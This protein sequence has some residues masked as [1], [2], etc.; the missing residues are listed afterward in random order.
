MTRPQPA[1]SIVLEPAKHGPTAIEALR[2]ALADP[3]LQLRYRRSTTGTWIDEFGLQIE[4]SEPDSG[5][6]LTPLERDG[7]WVAALI[8]DP[9]LLEEP[10]RVRAACAAIASVIDD[11]RLRAELRAQLRDEQA[12]RARI[13]AASDRQRRRI[14][15][16]L[17]D[18]AQQRLVGL[19]L[20]LQLAGKRADGGRPVTEL[21]V[22][23]VDELEA[24]IADLHELARGLHPAI[25]TDAGLAA[26]VETLAERPG[27]PVELFLDLP[28]R[29]PE[30][31][32]VG[33]YYLVAESLA[34]ANKHSGAQTITVTAG[35]VDDAVDV[36]VR[37]DGRGGADTTSGSGLV[38]LADRLGALGGHV[39]VDSEPG[40]GTT[41]TAH[42]PLRAPSATAQHLVDDILLRVVADDDA[43]RPGGADAVGNARWIAGDQDR[44]RRALKWIVWQNLAGPGEIIDAQP[45]TED[46]SHA[47]AL[48]LFVGGN[49]QISTQLRDWVIG[50]LTAAGYSESV[51]EAASAYD[52]SDTIEDILS[53]PRM[54]IARR[55]VLYDALRACAMAGSRFNPEDFD[56]VLRAADAVGISR[57][58][59]AD[60]HQIVI[61]EARLRQRRHDIVVAP[62]M[63]KLLHDSIAAIKAQPQ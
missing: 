60:L 8:H 48:L 52:D 27:I 14:E 10:G 42:I 59:V 63:P 34:N 31:V 39:I 7:D 56:P 35:V 28:E 6:C 40:R 26:A 32:E 57:D 1:G 44:R 11:E 46:M 58:V 49:R 50:Y 12:S 20:T 30:A 51:L 15:R 4:E 17:H 25:V 24:A 62:T 43:V 23:A 16:N 54:A 5:R 33:A 36:S 45:V 19:A 9:A 18:G 53:P 61:E 38:G 47:K 22:E 55:V 41:V 29:L 21:L 13:V 2:T 3:S 37:D